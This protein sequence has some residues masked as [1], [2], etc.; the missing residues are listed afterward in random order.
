MVNKQYII[1]IALL[2]MINYV[3]ML[4]LR[5]CCVTVQQA[6]VQGKVTPPYLQCLPI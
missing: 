6:M 4:M 5:D 3:A 2:S 1:M